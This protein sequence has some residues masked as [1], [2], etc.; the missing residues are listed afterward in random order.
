MA[1][2]VACPVG[3]GT[4]DD[5]VIADP[6]PGRNGRGVAGKIYNLS[7]LSSRCSEGVRGTGIGREV[8]RKSFDGR[9]ERQHSMA[10]DLEE[11]GR[12]QAR[13]GWAFG[14]L[15]QLASGNRKDQSGVQSEGMN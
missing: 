1:Y 4:G 13:V 11:K 6:A 3:Q 12:V 8:A 10:G 15:I 5:G 14:L 2:D 7:Q 9:R